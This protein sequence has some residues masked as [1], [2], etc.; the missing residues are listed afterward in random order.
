MT[1]DTTGKK[2]KSRKHAHRPE[3][4]TAPCARYFD[5]EEEILAFLLHFIKWTAD[6][7]LQKFESGEYSGPGQ[8]ILQLIRFGRVVMEMLLVRATDNFLTYVSELLA[9][10]FTTRPET[11]KSTETVRLE[12][13]LQY[14]T[15]EDLV[16]HLAERR[17]E[18]LSYQGM[19]DLQK[20]L[21]DRLGFELFVSA[22]SLSHAIRIIEVRNLIV[23]NRGIV[24]RLFQTR[25][26]DSK[27]VVG[28]PV[29]VNMQ[30]T[31]VD[32]L[33]FLANSVVEMDERAAV[34]FGLH[35]SS[36]TRKDAAT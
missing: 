23:H 22:E 35:R 34:K 20:D 21:A 19:R 36:T 26:G 14:S 33:N 16:Q 17:V 7:D 29:E 4:A 31:M 28:S 27:V 1:D 12:E 32:D 3:L 24:H 2:T 25:T 11:L 13:I 18:R 15:M 10:V 9:L 8:G 30:N 6:P 5:S